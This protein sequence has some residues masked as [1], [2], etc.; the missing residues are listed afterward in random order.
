MLI[1]RRKRMGRR[2]CGLCAWV[3]LVGMGSGFVAGASL[4]KAQKAAAAES[5]GEKTGLP[6]NDPVLERV[7][8]QWPEGRVDTVKNPGE[9][10][11]EEGVLLD[12]MTALW[13]VTGDGR[14][15]N[16]VRAAVDRS[17]DKD[18]TIHMAGGASFPSDAHSLDNIEMG[19][20]V[21]T[22]YEVL[23]QPRYYKAA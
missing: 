21:L 7:L 17:V 5:S 15:F 4:A 11:Y 3:A 10:A 20:S 1:F 8:R 16:Y 19:R 14:L 23:Q 18:G 13:R 22:L 6:V 9:W 2:L 12:G